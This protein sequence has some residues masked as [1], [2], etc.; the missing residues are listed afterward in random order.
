[1]CKKVVPSDE[2]ETHLVMCFTRPRI[3]YNGKCS[4]HIL[5]CPSDETLTEDRGECVIC[6]NDM[7]AGESI[8]RLPCLCIY[9]KM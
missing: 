5:S 6:F 8:A 2:A 7:N 4:G 9:H 1:M 3:T